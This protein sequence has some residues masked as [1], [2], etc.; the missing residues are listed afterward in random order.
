MTNVLN[1]RSNDGMKKPR[2]RLTATDYERLSRLVRSAER[3]MPDVAESLGAELDRAQVIKEGRHLM[4]V[5]CM[6]CEVMYRDETTG[7]VQKVVLVYPE[8]A[9]IA[10]GR[11]SVLTPIGA[12]LI[13]LAVGDAMNWE[14]RAGEIKRLTILQVSEP[15]SV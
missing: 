8:D 7:K 14:T 3:T 9:D 5:V 4:D 1:A 2:V 12:A 11:I 10:K 15:Q 13:G 6:G